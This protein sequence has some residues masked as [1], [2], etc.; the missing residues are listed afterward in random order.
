MHSIP[1][2]EFM[3]VSLTALVCCDWLCLGRR[4][5]MDGGQRRQ[6]GVSEDLSPNGFVSKCGRHSV[7]WRWAQ[8][9]TWN[10]FHC[11]VSHFKWQPLTS[12]CLR[13]SADVGGFVQDP[14]PEL[15]VRWYQAA[16][17]QPFFRGHSAKETK[18]REPWLFG[19]DVTTAIRTVIQQRWAL[20][21]RTEFQTGKEAGMMGAVVFSL[22]V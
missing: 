21:K 8:N 9:C 15:L 13:V 20:S 18:R 16:A 10:Y 14:E 19:G 2:D 12:S 17:L 4:S 5:N 11:W 22:V 3:V 7:L 1:C 6:L